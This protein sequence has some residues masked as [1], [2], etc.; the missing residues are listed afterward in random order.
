MPH[1]RAAAVIYAA[2]LADEI[3]LYLRD[4]SFDNRRLFLFLVCVSTHIE[5]N[6]H[7]EF[8]KKI[9]RDTVRCHIDKL[10]VGKLKSLIPSVYETEYKTSVSYGC[11]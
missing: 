7:I 4:L 5:S 3:G 2:A 6:A 8:S 9:Y 10:P 1:L 11:G